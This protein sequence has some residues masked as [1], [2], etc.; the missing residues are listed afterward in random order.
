MS[1]RKC[2]KCPSKI[3]RFSKTGMC[4]P[5][6]N[7]ERGIATKRPDTYC[8]CGKKLSRFAKHGTCVEHTPKQGNAPVDATAGRSFTVKGDDAVLLLR[9]PERVQT[10]KDLIRVCEIDTDEWEIKEHVV[11]GWQ[12]G[13]INRKTG[14]PQVAQLF[15]I[16]VWLKRKVVVL[17]A[18]AELDALRELAKTVLPA[19][20]DLKIPRWTKSPYL[21][22]ISIFDHHFGKLAWGRETGYQNYDLKIAIALYKRAVLNLLLRTA[23]FQFGRIV[24][25]IGQD[26]FNADNTSNTT[27][28]GTPQSTDG[29]YQKTFIEVRT[30]LVELIAHLRTIAPVEVIVVPG[31]HDTLASWHLGDSLASFFHATKDVFINN[32]PTP[33]KYVRHGKCLLGFTH[34][35]KGKAANLPGVML[36]DRPK[37]TGETIFREFHTGH[38][39]QTRLQEFHGVRVRTLSAL[40]PADAWHSENQY[41]GQQ[42]QAEAF[43]WHEN[44]GIV[45]TAVFTEVPKDA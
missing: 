24:F 34:G 31:N 44:E 18:K 20:P 8:H 32:E 27:T 30:M 3:T 40:C 43:V 21:L 19:L 35:D 12:Q 45:G 17:A 29:R 9:T 33:R 13:S 15:Q 6:A 39:H 4:S 26:M 38:I 42:R 1:N 14:D 11:N 36:S 5:C 28:K 37:D 25:V 10:L 2:S 41:V 16:K 22:E 7:A 23:Q